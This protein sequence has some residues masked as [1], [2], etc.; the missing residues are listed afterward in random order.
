MTGGRTPGCRWLFVAA[1]LGAA[2]AAGAAA[3][4]VFSVH[5]LNRD[6]YIDRAEY[7]RMRADCLARR[8]GR[9]HRPCAIEFSAMDEDG[10]GRVGERELLSALERW[11]GRY[12]W[13]GGAQPPPGAV[14]EEETVR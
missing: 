3:P 6:G 5:D 4:E 11:P 10:D 14:P 2:T 9:G 7:E 1:A 8:S 12:R 13:R